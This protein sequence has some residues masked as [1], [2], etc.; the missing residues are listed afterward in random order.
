MD[1]LRRQAEGRDAQVEMH[2][3]DVKA[4]LAMREQN[5]LHEARLAGVEGKNQAELLKAKNK[6]EIDRITANMNRIISASKIAGGNA[7]TPMGYGGEDF[8]ELPVA[9]AGGM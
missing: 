4:G 8:P 2:K 6:A 7:Q 5:L 1:E 9:P 3:T